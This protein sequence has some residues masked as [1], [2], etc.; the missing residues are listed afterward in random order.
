MRLRLGFPCSPFVA[1]ISLTAATLVA[2]VATATAQDQKLIEAGEQVYNNYCETCH[3]LKLRNS[4]Q[5]FDLRR[6]KPEERERFNRSVMNGKG[7]MPP[8][9]GVL[10]DEEMDQLWAYIQANT[11]NALQ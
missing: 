10:K 2:L 11:G 9:K 3:G 6:L 5:S 1:R 4:G 8:W 7:Q